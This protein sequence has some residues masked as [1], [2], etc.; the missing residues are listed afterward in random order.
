[1]RRFVRQ[2]AA[3]EWWDPFTGK[4]TGAGPGPTL[5]FDLAPY[6][7]RVVVFT[8]RPAPPPQQQAAAPFAPIDLSHDWKVTFDKTGAKETMQTLHSWADEDTE[9]YY[10]GTATYERTVDIPE[11]R[12][13]CRPRAAGFWRGNAGSARAASSGGHAHLVR[14]AA[15]RSRACLREWKAGRRGLA[16]AVQSE[17]RSALHSGANELKIVVAN[18]AINELAGRAAPDYRLLNLRY[19]E[20]FTPQDMDH[21][22]PLPSGILGPLRLIS[23]QD[24]HD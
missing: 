5:H 2:T 8:D 4:I 18:T 1:M 17:C 9:K 24:A 21:L 14:S 15:A 12:R 6:E 19:G 16:S 20:K 10:S 7:S 13:A 23:K 22:Q 11:S 3:R